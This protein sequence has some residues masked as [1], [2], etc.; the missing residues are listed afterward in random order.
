MQQFFEK[1]FFFGD[2]ME[3]KAKTSVEWNRIPQDMGG[4]ELAVRM[5]R[6]DLALE[7]RELWQ[8]GGGRAGE[9]AG[10]EVQNGLRDGLPVT[11]VRV[12]DEE[13]ERAL[14]KPRGCYV[15]LTLEGLAR[16]EE[17]VFSRAVQ[18]VSGELFELIKDIP[19]QATVLVAGL[20]N[21]SITPDA[22]GPKVHEYT[23]VTRHLVRCLPE[24][25]GALRPV[26]SLAA[27]VLGC[28]GV[29]SGEVVRAVCEKIRP[30]CVIAVDALASRSLER[31][32]RTVQLSDTGITPGSGVGNHRLG[33]NRETLG[34][35]V[36]AV[37][38]PTVVDGATLA[39]DLLGT[40]ELPRLGQG[41]EL[42]VTPKD[43]DS[44]V[45]D[46]S[47]VIGYGINLALQPGMSLEEL[48]LLL[49]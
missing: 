1:I 19:P 12:L 28:T 22:V 24:Q 15:T 40:E 37:G 46:L 10:V 11:T 21:R 33:L 18:A 7:A 2:R 20:G 44:Q 34:V 26:A 5:R 35:P 32:C 25:F 27:E 29:E 41:G 39:A 17:D 47:K 38:V 9:L 6:T 42:L 30:A 45:S 16:R 48:E 36:I 3:R 13:G 31:L 14:G 23:L 43:I 49:S 4:G 8:E